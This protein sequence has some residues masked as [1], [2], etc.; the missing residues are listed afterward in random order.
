MTLYDYMIIGC[1]HAGLA[2]ADAVR[3]VDPAG[4]I[5]LVDRED[6][7]PYS[8]TILPYVLSGEVPPG[9]TRLRDENAFRKMRA[10]F[11]PGE[12]AVRVMAGAQR[13]ELSSGEEI[14]YGKLLVATGARPVA[15]LIQG[16]QEVSY[17]VLRTMGDAARLREH[18]LAAR[19]ALILGAGLI[20][21]HAA[22]I[23]SASGAHV[24][25]VESMPQVLPGTFDPGA[26]ALLEEV[27]EAHGVRLLKGRTALSVERKDGGLS[28]SL[29]TGE[30]IAADLLLVA[31]G[32]RPRLDFLEGSGVRTDVG[33]LVDERMRTSVPGI[34]AAGDA[35]QAPQLFGTEPAFSPTVTNAADQGR[36]AG[37][38]MAGELD[39]VYGGAVI[40]STTSFF[41]HRAFSLGLGA[42]E[43]G[44][45]GLECLVQSGKDPLR[46]GRYVFQG[47][48]LVGVVGIS[49]DVDPGIFL[50]L[51]RRGVELDQVKGAMGENPA[52]TGRLLMAR[53][54]G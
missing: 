32:V 47:N 23:F 2:A 31:T 52:E 42:A 30:E 14:G 9:N 53:V 15:P 17:H 39:Q 16:L 28:L 38:D 8:P 40:A 3:A 21:M 22:E 29:N 19:K 11:R 1:S 7:L 6:R 36:T 37:L 34:W 5:L 20:G 43:S 35:A 50:E 48:R 51:I 45:E 13:V 24:T 18:M 10:V 33:I 27:F 12:E 41:G 54:W 26:A 4:G 25:V 44:E 46:Y 49:L